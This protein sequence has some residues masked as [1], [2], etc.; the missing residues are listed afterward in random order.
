MRAWLG[1]GS[2]FSPA[3]GSWSRPCEFTTADYLLPSRFL[4]LNSELEQ[5]AIAWIL[6]SR[7]ALEAKT[8]KGFT[9]RGSSGQG[10][11]LRGWSQVGLG[12]AT[13][14]AFATQWQN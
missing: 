2:C 6:V 13:G 12:P 10:R 11:E 5:P 3:G 8:K 1:Q 7:A 9:S 4:Y 14:S